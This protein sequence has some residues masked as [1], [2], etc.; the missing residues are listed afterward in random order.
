MRSLAV[1]ALLVGGGLVFPPCAIARTRP[2]WE[3]PGSM[4]SVEVELDGRAAPL[5]PAPDGS[6]R[7]YLEAREGSRYGVLLTNR[8]HER[9]GIV[10]TVDGL[11]AIS[12]R[13][14][15]GR[16]WSD[17]G[18]MYVL[19]PWDA[20]SV[21]GWR[22]SLDD[23]RR[24]M[25][26]DERSSYAA[27]TGQANA[28]T[29]WI[30]V[31]VYR[32]RRPHARRL[33]PWEPRVREDRGRDEG[34]SD[35]ASRSAPPA[36]EGH[37]DATPPSAGA[38]SPEAKA[39]ESREGLKALEESP[40]AESRRDSY[41]GTGWGPRTDDLAVVVEF[42]PQ[43]HAAERITFR[44]EYA[45]ALR[46]LGVFPRPDWDRLGERDRGTGFARPPDW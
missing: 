37:A 29:G 5:Y 4:V 44:Y 15:P 9:L 2:V 26:V 33:W 46:A 12:G 43:P 27:R 34:E 3:P 6:G 21:R 40:G 17:P 35:S 30:E 10:L 13:R 42:D 11:N 22:T 31:A 24:F 18:R 8:T 16:P 32:E 45:R 19:G 25:F 36:K 28:K 39:P 1:V 41:P 38:A 7:F 23:V 20:T 14:D